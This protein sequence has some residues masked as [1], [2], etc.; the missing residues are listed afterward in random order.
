MEIKKVLN[1]LN[2]QYSKSF[3]R[4]ES[5]YSFM[6]DFNE[7]VKEFNDDFLRIVSAVL[8]G[9]VEQIRASLRKNL[10]YIRATINEQ[11]KLY[12]ELLGANR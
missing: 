6:S 5:T 11:D 1:L 2:N 3:K 10:I 9:D 12:L 8:S 7:K 4:F